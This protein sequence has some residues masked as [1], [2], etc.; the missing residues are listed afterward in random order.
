MQYLL[1]CAGEVATKAEEMLVVLSTRKPSVCQRL[2]PVWSA[3]GS[4]DDDEADADRPLLRDNDPTLGLM[5]LRAYL[6]SA[7]ML[8]KREAE[9]VRRYNKL[10][11]QLENTDLIEER[12]WR[13]DLDQDERDN[14]SVIFVVTA[15]QQLLGTLALTVYGGA[16]RVADVVTSDKDPRDDT[17]L[18][19]RGLFKHMLGVLSAHTLHRVP[20]TLR[21]PAVYP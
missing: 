3:E 16:I 21:R 9:G 4:D 7:G 6:T 14:H 17:P 12:D 19:R 8:G 2:R 15:G 10:I 20:I 5:P 13:S 11:G 18:R 1:L